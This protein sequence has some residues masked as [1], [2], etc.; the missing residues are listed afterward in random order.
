MPNWLHKALNSQFALGVRKLVPVWIM[1]RVCRYRVKVLYSPEQ[2]QQMYDW[3][4]SEMTYFDNHTVINR[5]I[6]RNVISN[7]HYEINITLIEFF[8]RSKSSA[9]LFKLQF[10]DLLE[11]AN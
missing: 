7:G 5:V 8:F 9:A 4:K 1:K 6:E 11:E 10:S 3:I 2:Y